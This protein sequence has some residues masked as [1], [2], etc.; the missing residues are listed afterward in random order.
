MTI[1]MLAMQNSVLVINSSNGYET[2]ESLKETNP[3]GIVFDPLNSGRAYCATFGNGL[4]KTDDDGLT[5]SNIGNDVISS[6]YVMSV[7]VSPMSRGNKFNKVFAGTEPSAL[8]V[9]N[10]GGDSWERMHA[11]NDL[12]SSRSWSFPP[13]PWTH[14]IRWI[15]PDA[16]D[17]DYI[18]AA[19][20]AGALVQS[21][22]GGKTWI[23]RNEKQGPYDTHT[24][25]THSKAPKRLYSSAGDG[26]FESHDYGETWISPME[27][28]RHDYLFGIEVDPSN[29][30]VVIV[31]ASNGPSSSYVAEN[32][33]TFVYRKNDKDNKWEIVKD[34]LPEARGSTIMSFAANAKI[35]GEFYAVNNHGLFLSTDSGSSWRKLDTLWP[36]E[37]LQQTPWAIAIN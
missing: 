37:Y 33:E 28:V 21:R 12:P 31:S 13:R 8:Y 24:L 25:A 7:A 9:S 14:H 26:Y 35:P 17:P 3:Q 15:E 6:P 32:A 22:D 1:I 36:K 11:L 30:D 27:G 19:I 2:Q 18:F 23:D 34:G 4:W 16:N 10:D 29:P 5:W 20:E